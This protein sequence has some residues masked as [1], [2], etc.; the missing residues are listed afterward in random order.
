MS[1]RRIRALVGKE[2]AE[3]ARNRSALLPVIA[4][5][6]FCVAL[7]LLI[8]VVIPLFFQD[9]LTGD[10]DLSRALARSGLPFDRDRLT[11]EAVVQAFIFQQFML[12]QILV[13]VTGAIAFAGHSLIGEKQGRTL[14]PLL[15]TPLTTT[16]LLVGKGIGALLP[17]LG[18]MVAAWLL[19]LALI[20]I[21]ALPG[22]LSSVFNLRT[23]LL[24]LGV[25]PIASLVAL[26]I[27]V[28]VSSKVSDPRTAQQYGAL[29]ILPLTAL[30]AAQFTGRMTMHVG[31]ILALMLGLG[32][33]WVLLVLFGVAIFEREAI[34]TRWK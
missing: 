18:I 16:E 8:G 19:Y 9:P 34:L 29:L 5:A 10:Q 33:V 17:S 11:E 26:Q 27:G 6:L 12:M 30:F 4:L 22:V 28:I 23:V 25:G 31:A 7:P 13:P 3:L 32:A 24:V 15:A 2:L 21:F 20:G 1:W 14:E